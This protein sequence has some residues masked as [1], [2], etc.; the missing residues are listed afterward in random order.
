MIKIID[1]G[2]CTIGHSFLLTNQVRSV[3]IS[4]QEADKSVHAPCNSYPSK[5]VRL[6]LLTMGE[7]VGGI[8]PH[9]GRRGGILTEP[10]HGGGGVQEQRENF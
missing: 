1:I 7:T 9:G 6:D 3:N 4:F 8:H 5:K 10:H 2:F